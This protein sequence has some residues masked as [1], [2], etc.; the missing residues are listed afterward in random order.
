MQ[1]LLYRAE[2][3]DVE[4]KV[5]FFNTITAKRTL[6]RFF[7]ICYTPLM[8]RPKCPACSQTPEVPF[9]K[10]VLGAELV[11]KGCSAKLKPPSWEGYLWLPIFIFLLF[12]NIF[13]PTDSI[14]LGFL[15]A[16]SA[17]M[18]IIS[19]SAIFTPLILNDEL[20]D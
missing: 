4:L 2:I 13:L 19:L 8:K 9:M 20:N 14:W 16:I 6:D 1:N 7:H 3:F 17:L 18:V 11:C 5:E 10:R 15:I 12:I